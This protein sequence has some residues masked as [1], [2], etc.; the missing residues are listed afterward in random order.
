MGGRGESRGRVLSLVE[1]ESLSKLMKCSW[2][3]FLP[4]EEVSFYKTN[5]MFAVSKMMGAE[6]SPSLRNE[7]RD[8]LLRDEPLETPAWGPPPAGGNIWVPRQYLMN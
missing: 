4:K 7:F 8:G 1:R 5:R 6:I 3:F 2:H